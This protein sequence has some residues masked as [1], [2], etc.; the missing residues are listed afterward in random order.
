MQRLSWHSGQ[1]ERKLVV[2]V[3]IEMMHKLAREII[4]LAEA[5]LAE[6]DPRKCRAL[7]SAILSKTTDFI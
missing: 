3:S 7:L 2:L 6:T 1:P 4:K 5:V